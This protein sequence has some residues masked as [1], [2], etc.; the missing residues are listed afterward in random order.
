MIMT[1][2]E[3]LIA[4]RD[5]LQ[6]QLAALQE[7][8]G[9][10][11]TPET[12]KKL[13]ELNAKKA[14]A[15]SEYAKR[16]A[17]MEEVGSVLAGL[18]KKV[19]ALSGS[20]IDRILAAIK[21]QRWYFFKNKPKVLM[22]KST[23]LLWNNPKY[24][25]YV[26]EDGSS[27]NSNEAYEIEGTEINGYDN[28]HIVNKIEFEKIAYNGSG[29]PFHT[30]PQRQIIDHSGVWMRYNKEDDITVRW[31]DKDYARPGGT[32]VLLLYNSSLLNSDAEYEINITNNNIYTERERLQ[33]TLDIFVNNGLEPIFYDPEI[34]DIYHKL[35]IDQPGIISRLN[36][37]QAAIDTSQEQVLLSSSFDYHRFLV[38]YDLASIDSSVLQYAEAVQQYISLLLSKVAYFEKEKAGLLADLNAIG[39]KLAAPYQASPDLTN[40][41]NE[42]LSKRQDFFRNHF[43]VGMDEVKC[44]LVTMKREAKLLDRRIDE[45][46]HSS[47][48]LMELAKIEKED[49]PSFAVVAENGAR[50]VK[51]ALQRLE[52]FEQQHDF[53]VFAIDELE[54]WDD[55]YGVFKTARQQDFAH[56]CSDA[57]IGADVYQGWYADWQRRRFL[58]EEKF[59]PIIAAALLGK[60]QGTT[61]DG[62]KSIVTALVELLQSY[63]R[64]IDNFYMEER[65]GI[66]QKF[67]FEAGGDLQDKFETESRLFK[68]SIPF[69]TGLQ[70]L[71][72]SIS[73]EEDKYELLEWAQELLQIQIDDILQ[74]VQDK[75]LTQISAEVLNQFRQLRSANFVAYL[76]DSRAYSK[77]LEERE[78]EY[79]SLVFK[80]RKDLMKK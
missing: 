61:A 57:G 20:G 66:Y 37:V 48:P 27:Y 44:L 14:R 47:K 58:I 79:N 10:A 35:Y 11:D 36:E 80:M 62:A 23:G 34:T 3:E 73:D 42:L 26:R 15:A 25:P 8:V 38:D 29:F 53:A 68:L 64:T 2:I 51:R 52:F 49:R 17:A 1:D 72:F 22:D 43:V 41:E 30:G 67:A 46:N 31:T 28:W 33:F 59:T 56:A 60:L 69:Q 13:Q 45:A 7:V 21:N 70:N 5:E 6:E 40:E 32:P 24:V 50:I 77:A 12:A 63:K 76:A 71:I 54:K 55:E 74:Y 18:N 39:L 4:E 9:G 75:D 16:Q 65:M 78:K 19:A